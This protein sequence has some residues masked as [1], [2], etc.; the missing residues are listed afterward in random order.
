MTLYNELDRAATGLLTAAAAGATDLELH[1]LLQNY[2]ALRALWTP[3]AGKAT[4]VAG[5]RGFNPKLVLRALKTRAVVRSG[6]VLERALVA[7]SPLRARLL[8]GTVKD[9]VIPD[10][11]LQAMLGLA[12]DMDMLLVAQVADE[13][14]AFLPSAFTAVMSSHHARYS[15][16]VVQASSNFITAQR[17]VMNKAAQLRVNGVSAETLEECWKIHLRANPPGSSRGI[18]PLGDLPVPPER[19][20]AVKDYIRSRFVAEETQAAVA[21][22][23]GTTLDIIRESM[24]GSP[25]YKAKWLDVVKLIAEREH[26][27]VSAGVALRATIGPGAAVVTTAGLVGGGAFI[28]HEWTKEAL[29]SEFVACAE[30]YKDDPKA[31]ELCFKSVSAAMEPNFVA[32]ALVGLAGVGTLVYLN[33]KKGR[34][35]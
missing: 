7:S 15:P 26:L 24:S 3:E 12:D 30:K 23:N 13:A 14:P 31:Q 8:G 22:G 34:K 16:A 33:K 20:A 2:M 19:V 11:R 10:S 6:A 1:N 5:L 29:Q 25:E 27:P 35:R 4:P 32:P 17:A 28:G 9:M 21:Q 18:A